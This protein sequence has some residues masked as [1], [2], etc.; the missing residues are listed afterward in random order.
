[1]TSFFAVTCTRPLAADTD[2]FREQ[3]LAGKPCP[4]HMRT[5]I[6]GK[7]NERRDL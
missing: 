7:R 6:P 2:V 3:I 4:K 5:V 1:M